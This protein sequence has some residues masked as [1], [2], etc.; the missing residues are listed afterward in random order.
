MASLYEINNNIEVLTAQLVDEETGEVREDIL[1]ML[2]DLAIDQ[3]EKLENYGLVI[4]TLKAEAEALKAEA[5]VLKKRAESKLNRMERMMELVSSTL[6]GQPKE[7][8][9]VKYSFRPSQKVEIIN[10]EI[11][12]DDWC[13][14]ETKRIPKKNDIKKALKDG[15]KIPGCVLIDKKNLQVI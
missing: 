15:A 5:D 11:V 4:K 8:T 1:E 9:R 6:C 2:N 14:Y 10:E 3:D 7:Y 13:K 12:P